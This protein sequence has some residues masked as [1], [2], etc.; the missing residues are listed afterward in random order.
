LGAAYIA[1]WQERQRA[2]PIELAHIE[3]APES[4]RVAVETKRTTYFK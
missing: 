1:A 2:V 4:E 3:P